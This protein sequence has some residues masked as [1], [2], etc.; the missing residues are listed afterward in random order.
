[1]NNPAQI[2]S[3]KKMTIQQVMEFV[4]K[5]NP[6]LPA[7]SP[8][9]I[10]TS[11]IVIP[12]DRAK[13]LSNGTANSGDSIVS[14]VPIRFPKNKQR[15][16]KDEIAMMDIVASNNWERPIYYAVTCRPEKL[17]GLSDY[18]QLEGLALRIVPVKSTGDREFQT[19][20]IG[21]GRVDAERM[22][23]NVMNKFRWGNFDKEELYVN[24]SYMPSV[25]SNRFAMLR[26]ARALIGKGDKQRATNV[27][28]KYFE[29]FPHK[30]F[31]YDHN[32]MYMIRLYADVGA[33]TDGKAHVLTLARE[34]ADQM[35]FLDSL[36]EQTLQSAFGSE[37][38]Q[39]VGMMRELEDMVKT[40]P[41]YSDIKDEVLDLFKDYST[42]G[43][44]RD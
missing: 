20:P 5:D 18:L 17:L 9:Y 6:Q 25:A 35:E 14:E 32:A 7:E 42:P 8:T 11:N 33:E 23:D 28:N 41:G 15:L 24:E 16:I 21:Q 27:L 39:W 31:P 19:M 38:Q 36:D 12:V 26:L 10:P 40:N 43:N 22:Y 4:S 30:N 2:A 13:V 3:D 29:V 1:M 34:T 44:L 37:F